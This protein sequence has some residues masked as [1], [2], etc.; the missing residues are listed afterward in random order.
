MNIEPWDRNYRSSRSQIFFKIGVL[1]DFGDFTGKNL[2]WSL[3]LIKLQAW[4][5]ST[6]LRRD[7]NTGIFLWIS[8]IFRNTFFYRTPPVATFKIKHVYASAAVLLH[9]RIGN[10]DWCKCGHCKNKAREIDCL[11][12]REVNSMLTAL[13]KIPEGKGS[14]ST[15]RFYG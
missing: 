6:L 9:I 5:P 10:N 3:F 14:I 2:C 1:K 4:R 12:C 8:K 11:C 7:C 13:A 15:C